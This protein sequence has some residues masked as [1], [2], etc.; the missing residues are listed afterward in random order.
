MPEDLEKDEAEVTNA[1]MA[2][3]N[4][5]NPQKFREMANSIGK[6]ELSNKYN[7]LK[8]K[9]KK[10]GPIE[11][12]EVKEDLDS[13]I[14]SVINGDVY[15]DDTQEDNIDEKVDKIIDNTMAY[16][17]FENELSEILEGSSKKAAHGGGNKFDELNCDNKFGDMTK[18]RFYDKDKKEPGNSIE[19][20]PEP[21]DGVGHNKKK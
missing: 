11:S 18:S 9:Y 6:P 8:S 10:D 19:H 7:R 17:S 14:S 21:G 13:I 20:N 1:F 3:K 15:N 16:E 2:S 5:N 4:R 12:D